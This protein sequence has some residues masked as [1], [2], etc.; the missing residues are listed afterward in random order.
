MPLIIRGDGRKISPEE[1]WSLCAR[2]FSLRLR[3]ERD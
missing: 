1:G 3:V 2:P